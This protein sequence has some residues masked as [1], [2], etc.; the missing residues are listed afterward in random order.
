MSSFVNVIPKENRE[1][2]NRK[3]GKYFQE[4]GAGSDDDSKVNQKIE[5]LES[6]LQ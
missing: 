6:W 5:E 1:T 4:V 2:V 3:N